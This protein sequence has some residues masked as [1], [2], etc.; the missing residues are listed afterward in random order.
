MSDRWTDHTEVSTNK[1]TSFI[2][3][4]II[5]HI[6]CV[7]SLKMFIPAAAGGPVAVVSDGDGAH[8]GELLDVLVNRVHSRSDD[9]VNRLY[10]ADDD[11]AKSPSPSSIHLLHSHSQ[12][13]LS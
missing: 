8:A 10:R 5:E 12:R 1:H 6:N 2:S 3:H 4:L 7:E 11:Q 13:H 9:D